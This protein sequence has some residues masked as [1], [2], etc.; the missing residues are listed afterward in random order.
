MAFEHLEGPF[1][2]I[3][4]VQKHIKEGTLQTHTPTS[5]VRSLPIELWDLVQH[6]VTD[7]EL[8]AAQSRFLLERACPL[9]VGAE[10]IPN[11]DRRLMSWAEMVE[12]GICEGTMN[13]YRGLANADLFKVRQLARNLFE[14]PHELKST[15]LLLQLCR[16]LRKLYGLDMPS[17]KFLASDEWYWPGCRPASRPG[18]VAFIALSLRGPRPFSP[19]DSVDTEDHVSYEEPYVDRST[20]RHNDGIWP[21]SLDTPADADQRNLLRDFRLTPL[22]VSDGTIGL[23]R[24]GGSDRKRFYAEISIDQVQPR[25][26]VFTT[27]ECD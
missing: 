4:L 26:H 24:A 3:R 10:I 14:S 11:R 18:S 7:V 8:D 19:A 12:Y 1:R 25:S 9:C 22:K 17:S 16:L 21:V 13:S 23:S 5:A 6:K 2:F 15:R 27:V 20:R